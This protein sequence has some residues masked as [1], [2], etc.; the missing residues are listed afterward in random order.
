[1]DPVLATMLDVVRIVTFQPNEVNAGTRRISLER[2]LESTNAVSADEAA[3]AVPR[4]AREPVRL[5]WWF[6][7]SFRHP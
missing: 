3:P 7:F 6:K 2:E 1:M 5:R 4:A